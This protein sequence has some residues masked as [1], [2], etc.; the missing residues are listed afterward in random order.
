MAHMLHCL[1]QAEMQN[2]SPTG[3][4]QCSSLFGSLRNI[5]LF[6]LFEN[7]PNPENRNKPNQLGTSLEGA[8]SPS[9][10]SA[11]IVGLE[12]P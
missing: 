9:P 11:Q 3:T 4:F 1:S 6:W 12:G 2:G 5:Q 7:C 10:P 8:G